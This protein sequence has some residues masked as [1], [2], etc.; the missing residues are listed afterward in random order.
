MHVKPKNLWIN[1]LWPIRKEV[2]LPSALV[3]PCHYWRF[4]LALLAFVFIAIKETIFLFIVIMSTF[5]KMSTVINI[6]TQFLLPLLVVG[7]ANAGI[8]CKLKVS[9]LEDIYIILMKCVCVWVFVCQEKWSYSQNCHTHWHSA[10][11]PHSAVS[12]RHQNHH[13]LM[14]VSKTPKVIASLRG[15]VGTPR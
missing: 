4:N 2:P 8:Y 12:E 1:Y 14:R 6:L 11:K 9:D 13:I 10:Q 7:I 3:D 15:S 5:I